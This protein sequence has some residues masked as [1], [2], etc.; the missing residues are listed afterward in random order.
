MTNSL[1]QIPVANFCCLITPQTHPDSRC[2]TQKFDHLWFVVPTFPESKSKVILKLCIKQG[3]GTGTRIS[4]SCS[5][6]RHLNFLAPAP[7]S[8]YFLVLAPERFGP[9]KTKNHCITCITRLRHKKCL[10]NRNQSLRLRPQ[11][12]KAF[13][14]FSDHPKLFGFRLHSPAGKPLYACA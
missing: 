6:S 13:G 10:R 11:H 14:S 4:G 5:S 1:F 12:L 2:V 7:I 8:K 3:C 9:L